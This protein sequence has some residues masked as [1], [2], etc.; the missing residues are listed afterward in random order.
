MRV[1]AIH[2][3]CASINRNPLVEELSEKEARFR[4]KMKRFGIQ[5]G[6]FRDS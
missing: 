2:A 4:L 5:A 6:A 3:R 1:P